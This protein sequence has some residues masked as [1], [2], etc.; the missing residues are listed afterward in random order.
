MQTLPGR[1]YARHEVT[2]DE[3]RTLTAGFAYADTL[4]DEG[5]ISA[6]YDAVVV[7]GDLHL[8]SLQLG[9]GTVFLVVT[10]NLTIDGSCEDC[11]DPATGLYVLGNLQA[12]SVFTAGMLGVQGD[13]TV[14]RTLAGYYNDYSA[15]VKGRTQ[16]AVFFP[17]NHFFEFGGEPT[18]GHVLGKSA[19]HRVPGQWAGLMK[20]TLLGRALMDR[21]P[22]E[23]N[24]EVAAFTEEEI[25]TYGA[26]TL[27]DA[28]SLYALVIADKPVLT[29]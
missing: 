21:F 13:L 10:G 16:A 23:D 24:E 7:D 2:L 4:L 8:P 9:N 20:E 11:D 5:L 17:E 3:L 15:I 26:S 19:S 22:G 14:T 18:F 1:S 29:D 28:P 25:A 27:L 6:D 12:G